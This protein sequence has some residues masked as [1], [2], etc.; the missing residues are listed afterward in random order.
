MSNTASRFVTA[1][2][3]LFRRQGYNGTSLSQVTAAA[4]APTGSLYHHFKGGKDDLTV[5]VLASAGGTYLE[6]LETVWEASPDPEAAVSA[7]FDGAADILEATD[8]IDP[9]PIGTVAREVASTNEPLR[10]AALDQFELW[11]AA[12]RQRL[13]AA[14]LDEATAQELAVT[15][16]GAIEGAFVVARTARDGELVRATG[17]RLSQTVATELAA[18]SQPGV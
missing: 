12:V 1:T 17:R 18:V 15:L 2:L 13:V 14:G 8:F 4:G 9:C 11:I 7:F 3:E 6:L 10:I 5:A 16:V